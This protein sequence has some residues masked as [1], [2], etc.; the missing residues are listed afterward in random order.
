LTAVATFLASGGA[1]ASPANTAAAAINVEAA[2]VGSA[3]AC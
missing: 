3:A 1:A 2:L